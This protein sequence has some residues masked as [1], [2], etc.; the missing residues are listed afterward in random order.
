MEDKDIKIFNGGNSTA[1]NDSSDLDLIALAE[2][3]KRNMLSGN[4]SKA[5]E[6]G[7]VLA[8]FSPDSGRVC[9]EL[10]AILSDRSVTNDIKLQ[11]RILM[12]FAAEHTLFRVLPP[13]IAATASDAMYDKLRREAYEFYENV[14]GGTSF[15]FYYLAVKKS[16]I[17]QSIGNSFAML[18]NAENNAV[19]RYLGQQTFT[20][21]CSQIERMIEDCSFEK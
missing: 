20:L 18:C 12:V 21:M 7:A 10:K 16:N 8:E 2:D 9:E 5:K 3:L 4:S 11:L 6:L 19:I 15:T 17:D 1:D 13:L 14:S